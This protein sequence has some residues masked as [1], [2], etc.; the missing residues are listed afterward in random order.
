M[1]KN[2]R[3]LHTFRSRLLGNAFLVYIVRCAISTTYDDIT[4]P[5]DLSDLCSFKVR[6]DGSCIMWYETVVGVDAFD[7]AGEN[8]MPSD[9]Q[10]VTERLD[11]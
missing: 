10:G 7:K 4:E 2:S 8:Y 5:D 3:S 11:T 1:K 9:L 6:A